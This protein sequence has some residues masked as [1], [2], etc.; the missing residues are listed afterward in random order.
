MADTCV[1]HTFEI[2]KDVCRVCQNSY[3]EECL[4]YSFGPKKPPYCVTCALAAAGIRHAGAAPNPRLQKKKG[5]FGRKHIVEDPPKREP[6]FDDIQIHLPEQLLANP[7]MMKVTRRTVSPE[8]V[9]AVARADGGTLGGFSATDLAD[10]DAEVDDNSAVPVTDHESLAG[11]AASLTET[12]TE[13][14]SIPAGDDPHVI[15]P[16]PDDTSIGGGSAF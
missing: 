12:E 5:L 2:A 6:S 14:T 3:C 1:K 7:S 15:A 8:L 9:D 13:A 16:W 11:W 10:M 4:V